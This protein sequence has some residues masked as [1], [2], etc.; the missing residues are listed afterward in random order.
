[1]TD[2]L[3]P[4]SYPGRHRVVTRQQAGDI[5]FDQLRVDRYDRFPCSSPFIVEGIGLPSFKDPDQGPL[6]YKSAHRCRKCAG[7]LRHRRNLWVARAVAEISASNRTWFGTLTVEPHMRF[8]LECEAETRLRAGGEYLRDLTPPEQFQYLANHL[9]KEVTRWLKRLR[10]KSKLRYLLVFEAHKDG[11]PHVHL[12]LH[13]TGEAIRKRDLEAQWNY[14][15]SNWRLVEKGDTKPA[16]Y[17]SKYLVKDA[18]T[19]I[20]ASQNYGQA[21]LVASLTEQLDALRS[22]LH[23]TA[24]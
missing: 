12:L 21:T 19:R 23:R 14:G 1:M 4:R 24:T 13:E 15:F 16:W 17:V 22:R 7:C 10:K 20:R 18:L 2:P 11:F 6:P 9:G 5:L 3:K 8:K